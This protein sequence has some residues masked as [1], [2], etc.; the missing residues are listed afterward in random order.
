MQKI[1]NITSTATPA[2]EFT[3]G[4]VSQ[5]IVP[6]LIDDKWLNTIQR[7]LVKVVEASGLKLDPSDDTQ[8]WQ[9]IKLLSKGGIQIATDADIVKGVAGKLVDAAG[10]RRRT[11]DG[12][13]PPFS[14]DF[15]AAIGGYP[16]GAILLGS[17]GETL[18]QSTADAN[19]TDPDSATSKGWKNLNSVN[20]DVYDIFIGM[21]SFFCMQTAPKG[22]LF[23]NGSAV[24]RTTYAKLFSKIGTHYGGGDGRTTFTLP[25]LRGEFLRG[26]DAGRGLDSGRNIGTQQGDAIRNIYGSGSGRDISSQP[27]GAFYPSSKTGYAGYGGTNGNFIGFDASRV[28]PTANENRPRNV[29]LAVYIYAGA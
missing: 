15:A 3:N 10:L 11:D 4:V 12:R 16:K 26:W 13:Q 14:A 19:T 17:D 8:V 7:E 9:A 22:W 1:G 20:N 2:G 29:A 25:D 5:G 24:S 28:V 21:T 6:T 23:A 27:S 18:W